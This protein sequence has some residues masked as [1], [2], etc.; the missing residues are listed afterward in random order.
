MAV[1]LLPIIPFIVDFAEDAEGLGIVEEIDDSEVAAKEVRRPADRGICRVDRFAKTRPRPTGEA[2]AERLPVSL[3]RRPIDG[4]AEV[5][6]LAPVAGTSREGDEVERHHR[7]RIPVA[8]NEL[9]GLREEPTPR[10]VST[11]RFDLDVVGLDNAA[12]EFERQFRRFRS[13]LLDQFAGGLAASRLGGEFV[14]N[15][16]SHGAI[17]P[18]EGCVRERKNPDGTDPSGQK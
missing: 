7:I 13:K 1:A 12:D 9:R 4:Q 18:L 8:P 6:L 3:D 17:R 11:D 16:Q 14:M 10:I 15:G 5:R 2:G